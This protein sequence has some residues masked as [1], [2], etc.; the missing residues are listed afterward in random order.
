M[1]QSIN[2]N[3][4][5]RPNISSSELISSF[6]AFLLDSMTSLSSSVTQMIREFSGSICNV[7]ESLHNRCLSVFA[8]S[9]DFMKTLNV[10]CSLKLRMPSIS[11]CVLPFPSTIYCPL[12]HPTTIIFNGTQFHNEKTY[13]TSYATFCNVSKCR[14]GIS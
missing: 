6:I 1:D 9:G 10:W 5:L 13:P 7:A 8:D 14:H 2:R 11:H 12:L 3:L 4:F